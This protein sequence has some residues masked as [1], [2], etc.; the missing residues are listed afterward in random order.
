M[1]K[2]ILLFT[3]FLLTAT[4]LSAQSQKTLPE[5]K[6]PDIPYK[7]SITKGW[8]G[9]FVYEL[10]FD[11][12]TS[13]GKGKNRNYCRVIINRINSG[14]VE[15]PTEVRGAIRSNQ[16]DKYNKERYESWIRSGSSNCWNKHDET[17]TIIEPSAGMVS[18]AI[19]GRIEKYS[20]YT[21]SSD[22]V[23]GWLSNTDL[24]IDHT[25][26]KY[27]FAIPVAEYD[28]EGDE[29]LVNITYNPAKNEN[30]PRKEKKRH[31]LTNI[32]YL[33]FGDWNMLEGAFAEG[34]KEII[35]RERIPVTLQL[36][37]L[38]GT[39]TVKSPAKK[40]FIDFYLVLKR[41]G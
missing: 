40:G 7:P 19:T 28:L 39:N 30:N 5:I 13:I 34:Q 11:D 18:D 17:D 31:G 26:G 3:V 2:N 10:K 41:V 15:F 33:Q 12:S 1:K 20:R 6:M 22:W 16:P 29:T 14:Y 36:S 38:Q 24:Q 21:S 9:Q 32:S 25:T 23:K 27:S 8:V 35:F 4:V 37:M